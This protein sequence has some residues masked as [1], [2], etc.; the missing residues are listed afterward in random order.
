MENPRPVSDHA[1]AEVV[2]NARPRD[3]KYAVEVVEKKK[4]L[5]MVEIKFCE[6]EVV[7]MIPPVELVESSAFATLERAR[8]E[9]VAL[10][11]TKRL[12]V[13]VAPPEIVR[14]AA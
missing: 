14:P 11:C 9:V 6:S 3:E 8:F 7:A 13:V 12:P 10:P 4:P 2:E 1:S 5:S